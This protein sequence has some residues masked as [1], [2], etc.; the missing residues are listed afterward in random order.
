MTYWF[1][2]VP[3]HSD[4]MNQIALEIIKYAPVTTMFFSAVTFEN[5]YCVVVNKPSQISFVNQQ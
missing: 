3:I 5:L 2:P 4:S 1:E